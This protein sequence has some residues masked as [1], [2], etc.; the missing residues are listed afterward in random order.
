MNIIVFEDNNGFLNPFSIN[1]SPIELRIGAINNF[2]R[3]KNIF[4][5]D[6][7]ILVV[8]DSLKHVIKDKFPECEVNPQYI[9]RGI[10]LNSSAIFKEEHLDVIKEANALSNDGKLIAFHLDSDV[11]LE[12][13]NDLIN[14]NIE[15]TKSCDIDII[16]NLW[17]IFNYSEKMIKYDFQNFHSNN[18][19]SLH[20]SLIRINED[21][22]HI[23]DNSK[24]KAGIVLD[25]TSGPIIIDDNVEIGHGVIIEGPC[26]IGQ[27]SVISPN[28]I[29]RKNN[30]FGPM[31]KI[32][33]EV[34]CC[35]ILGYSNK[36]HEGFLGHSYVGEWVNIGAGTNNS[37]LKNNY[38]LVKVQFE[39][40]L[41]D[42]KLK[43]LGS[44]IGDYTRIS[45]GTNLNT[46]SYLGLG[47]NLFNHDFSKK[48]IPSFSWGN[49]DRVKIKLLIETIIKM[50]KRRSCKLSLAEEDLI[51]FLY[52]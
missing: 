2:N 9:P 48:Y 27:N 20:H 19:Y 12:S 39:N 17:D 16:N 22:I 34:S 45:I 46:G 47:V 28:S 6:N 41:L 40:T 8:R 23:G 5:N 11:Q 25:A 31:C 15:V 43:F 14:Q 24:I 51:N 10:C 42:T 13:F 49:D 29:I 3:I 38:S 52:K 18:N 1:H 30:V 44:L 50:K 32:G 7:F 33:G 21:Y 26:Y 4:S 36:V 35:N 37:N